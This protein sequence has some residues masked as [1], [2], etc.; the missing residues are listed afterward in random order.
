MR[1]GYH[2][3]K[4]HEND[5]WK[6]DFKTKWDL[7]EWMVMPFGICNA[8]T[9]FMWIMNDVFRPLINDF[10]IFY[11]DDILILSRTSEEHVKH[12]RQALGILEREKL[13][14]NMSK[15]DFGT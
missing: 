13:Y 11:L 12:V 1:S 2:Q 7:Y 15:C 9:T 5:I 10:V 8:P 14:L 4:I 6:T 3:I